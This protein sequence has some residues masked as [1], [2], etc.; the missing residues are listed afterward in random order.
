MTSVVDAK[1][2]YLQSVTGS[3]TAAIADLE[4]IYYEQKLE[5]GAGDP[6]PAATT[7]VVG[8]VKKGVAVANATD[9]ASA[10]TQL[11]ALLASLRAAGTIAT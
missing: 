6:V 8:G 11:N 2:A 5:G 3:D 1:R 4:A 10:V 7:S 9:E